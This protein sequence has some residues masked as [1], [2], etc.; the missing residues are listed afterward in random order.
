MSEKHNISKCSESYSEEHL[1]KYLNNKLSDEENE[2]LEVH[3]RECNVCSD[4]LDGLLMMEDPEEIF[5]ISQDINKIIDSKTKSK[6]RILGMNPTAIRA[7]AAIFILVAISG[8]YVILDNII[9]NNKIQSVGEISQIDETSEQR[10]IIEN[11]EDVTL[12]PKES[13]PMIADVNKKGETNSSDTFKLSHERLELETETAQENQQ[14]FFD[15]DESEMLDAE[16]DKYFE[17]EESEDADRMEN[18]VSNNSVSA[19]ENTTVADGTVFG[20]GDDTYTKQNATGGIIATGD[21]KE[22]T[23]SRV[24]TTSESKDRFWKFNRRESKKESAVAMK[25][26]EKPDMPS[27]ADRSVT[28]STVDASNDNDP[29]TSEAVPVTVADELT[30]VEN[31]IEAFDAVE[32]E[33]M[34]DLAFVEEDEGLTNEPLAFALVEEK[35]QYPGGDTAMYNYISQ[36]Y[37]L[38]EAQ[39]SQIGGKIFVQLIIES[40]GKVSNVKIARGIDPYL[41]Q[42]ALRVV[43]SMPN[44]IPGKQEGKAVPVTFILP[45]NIE[46]E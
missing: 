12:S 43:R 21:Q 46:L 24:Y 13:E 41:D 29:G 14:V 2:I 20:A 3:L 35:P 37:R 26:N 16:A 11:E 1:L 40:T 4:Q 36:N 9:Q 10:V 23:I 32:E 19:T 17:V 8:A 27:N 15:I 42:E 28:T 33:V 6:K 30:I 31:D 25:L 39:E 22:E 18:F 34:I 5:A 38:P 7:V 45:I 44:W